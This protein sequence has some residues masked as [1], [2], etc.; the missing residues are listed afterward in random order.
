MEILP[1]EPVHAVD[2]PALEGLV[3][4]HIVGIGGD[5]HGDPHPLFL[6][7]FQ[8]HQEQGVGPGIADIHAAIAAFGNQLRCGPEHIQLVSCLAQLT[9]RSQGQ[10]PQANLAVV[11]KDQIHSKI[12]AQRLALADHF[13]RHAVQI[14]KINGQRRNI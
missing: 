9:L 5:L 4:L 1:E 2:D 6:C 11:I 10:I 13:F 14:L 3:T 8:Q 12:A 7:L